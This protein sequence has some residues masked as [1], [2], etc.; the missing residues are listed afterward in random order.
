MQL[1]FKGACL[2]LWRKK[3]HVAAFFAT[4]LG[5]NAVYAIRSASRTS[6]LHTFFV[7][8]VRR[9]NKIHVLCLFLCR[10]RIAD[11]VNLSALAISD[12]DLIHFAHTSWPSLQTWYL[13]GWSWQIGPYWKFSVYLL[14]V[15]NES[16]TSLFPSNWQWSLWNGLFPHNSLLRWKPI[17][18]QGSDTRPKKYHPFNHS[19]ATRSKSAKTESVIH[20]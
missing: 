9:L 4:H 16:C 14:D 20:K 2:T 11:N 19:S 6:R 12:C 17:K 8:R 13:L 15:R 7:S 3:C 10:T 1:Q 5:G 18:L